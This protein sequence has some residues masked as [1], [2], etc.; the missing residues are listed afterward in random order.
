MT[1][2][3]LSLIGNQL[4]ILH[5]IPERRHRTAVIFRAGVSL[6][7]LLVANAEAVEPR[8]NEGLRD[9][10]LA[11]DLTRRKALFKVKSPDFLGVGE[12]RR[13]AYFNKIK[14]IR[15]VRTGLGS[16]PYIVFPLISFP[17]S[18]LLKNRSANVVQIALNIFGPSFS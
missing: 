2:P 18:A 12:F 13:E 5:G 10:Q 1:H 3:K 4:A 14:Q 11:R 16:M 7:I 6:H 15:G 17:F 8:Q 9:S